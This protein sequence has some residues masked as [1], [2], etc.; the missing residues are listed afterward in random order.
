MASYRLLMVGAMLVALT[1]CSTGYYDAR[2]PIRAILLG[3]KEGY[4]DRKGPGQLDVV[5]FSANP[6]TK[7][8]MIGAYLMYRCAELGQSRGKPYFSM[9][10]SISDAIDD[11]PMNTY[12]VQFVRWQPT[13][14]V[15]VLYRD[16]EVPGA[17]AVAETLAK[18]H[19]QVKE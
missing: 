16:V 4:W 13:A 9:Y 6:F 11:V 1:G 2:N 10:Y 7:A 5:G 14:K 19:S 8:D 15:Y 3:A 12:K 17:F 18:Y